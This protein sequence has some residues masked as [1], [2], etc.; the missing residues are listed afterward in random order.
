MYEK[1]VCCYNVS[2]FKTLVR[3]DVTGVAREVHGGYLTPLSIEQV[4]LYK[5]LKI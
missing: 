4:Q 5:L 1:N 3:V 2:F